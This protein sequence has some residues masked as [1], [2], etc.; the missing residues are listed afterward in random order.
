[1][2][3]DEGVLYRQRIQLPFGCCARHGHN[4]TAEAS[5][6]PPRRS[7]PPTTHV[8]T[9]TGGDAGAWDVTFPA[10]RA[11]VQGQVVP[12]LP[13]A[14]TSTAARSS[15]SRST[16]PTSADHAASNLAPGAPLRRG[17]VMPCRWRPVFA[18]RQRRDPERDHRCWPCCTG[19]ASNRLI[20]GRASATIITGKQGGC[21]APPNT[22]LNS[23]S[24]ASL[25][26]MRRGIGR[27]A[28]L[29]GL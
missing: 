20:P 9:R 7:R 11:T 2:L 24:K 12:Y 13:D 29:N 16:T 23:R 18:W 25:N 21:S 17:D 5:A 4:G 27:H 14:S 19:S 15:A 6:R 28:L 1:M 8:A 10:G 22:G 26:S 3:A